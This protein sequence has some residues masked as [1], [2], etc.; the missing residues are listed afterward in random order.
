MSQ[1][2]SSEL[3][4]ANLLAEYIAKMQEALTFN[5][6]HDELLH[7]IES[8]REKNTDLRNFTIIDRDQISDKE[9]YELCQEWLNLYVRLKEKEKE[10]E[11]WF[12]SCYEYY[13]TI[14]V[15]ST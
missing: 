5:Y 3:S 1:T 6:V 10:T 2:E 11:D 9:Y 15:S 8:L 7:D 4:K 14:D 13:S 12:T